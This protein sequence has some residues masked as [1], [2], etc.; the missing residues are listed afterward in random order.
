[1]SDLVHVTTHVSTGLARFLEQYKEKDLFNRLVEIYL[2]E[3]Q[4]VE[5]AVWRTRVS[6]YLADAVG[7]QLDTLGAIVGE[8][9]NGRDDDLYRIW[10]A[11]RIRLNRSR[12]TPE[13]I[14]DCIKL[15]TDAAFTYRE[16]H[17]AALRVTFSEMP[18]FPN[19]IAVIVFYAKA[20]ATHATVWFPATFRF[21]NVGGADDPGAGFSDAG[22]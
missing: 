20:I 2:E 10:I 6:H 7:E 18:D 17:E 22:A 16:F 21:K 13:D 15:A 5:D 3:V 19:D 9:R 4:E 8:L 1:M 12:G 11:V 14:I